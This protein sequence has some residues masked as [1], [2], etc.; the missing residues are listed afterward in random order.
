MIL[1]GHC[2][3]N[4]GSLSSFG[5]VRATGLDLQHHSVIVPVPSSA[6]GPVINT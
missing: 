6:T 2:R 1:E 4:N 5:V 3:A